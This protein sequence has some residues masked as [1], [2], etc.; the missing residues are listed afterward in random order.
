MI[1]VFA[2][3]ALAACSSPATA[4]SNP[5]PP[6]APDAGVDAPEAATAPVAPP[7]TDDEC[8]RYVDHV[9]ELGLAAMRA[10]KPA[11]LVPTAEQVAES[12]A[13]LLATAPCRELPRAAWE[14][15]LAAA[16]QAALYACATTP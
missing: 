5:T 13:R 9:L 14:C 16:D 4:P 2:L 7:L 3:A 6:V 10:S 8:A 15:A 12:R 11:E 1:R